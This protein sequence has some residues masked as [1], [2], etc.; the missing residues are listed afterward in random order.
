[1]WWRL[2]RSDFNA[3]KGARNK[4]AFQA[5]VE[6]GEVPGVLAYRGREPVGWCAVA[7]R[8]SYPALGRSK[9]L[10]PVDE[11][12]VWSVTCFFVKRGFRKHGV[13]RA[14]LEAA[15]RLARSRGAR[16][17][18][19]YPVE[20]VEERAPDAFVWTGLAAA[21][22][23]AGFREVERRSPTRPIMRRRL[24]ARIAKKA[25]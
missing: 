6:S 22:R 20:P 9:I 2:A 5:L 19:G 15:V 10:A 1:M 11:T 17:V 4:R 24:R 14:L 7:P 25:R 18:E 21:F 16:A 3:R 12:P 8:E 23:K 13:S